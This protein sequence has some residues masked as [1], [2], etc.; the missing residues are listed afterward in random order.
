MEH[1][2]IIVPLNRGQPFDH[3]RVASAKADSPAG[4]VVTLAHRGKF[5]PHI[6]R[7]WRRQKGWWNVSIVRNVCVSKVADDHQAVLLRKLHN[8]HKKLWLHCYRR[9]IMWVV[10]YK[11]LWSRIEMLARIRDVRKVLFCVGNIESHNIARRK[12]DRIHMSRKIRCWNNS[13]VAS[14]H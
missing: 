7:T 4:H 1:T 3:V 12:N 13:R 6:L 10:D 11:E 9:R 2:I 5:D 14:S 8:V